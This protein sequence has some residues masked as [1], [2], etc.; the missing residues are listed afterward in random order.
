MTQGVF[1]MPSSMQGAT[2]PFTPLLETSV[3]GWAE[4]FDD[5]QGQRA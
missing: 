4:G 3:L 2:P 1:T 5:A